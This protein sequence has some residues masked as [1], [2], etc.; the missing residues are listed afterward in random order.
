M[1]K[2]DSF[3]GNGGPLG[4]ETRAALYHAG[5][6]LPALDIVYGL[7]GRDVRVDDV[8]QVFDMLQDAARGSEI[9]MYSYIGVRE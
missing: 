1:D 7:G 6:H 5:L 8:Y 3:S 2:T 4:A 9:P